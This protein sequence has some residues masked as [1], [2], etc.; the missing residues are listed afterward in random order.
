MLGI[1]LIVLA[2]LAAAGLAIAYLLFPRPPILDASSL[3]PVDGPRSITVVLVDATDDL[4][5]VTKQEVAKRLADVAEDLPAYGLLDLRV[6]DPPT[7]GSRS[8]FARCN[9]GDGAGLS[10]FTGNPALARARW[11]E[12]F[13]KPAID[14]VNNSLSS[15]EASFSP[16]MA[17]IQRI[18]IERFTGKEL[19]KLPR[20]LIVVSDMLEN[21]SAYEQYLGDLT[22]QRYQNSP[23]YRV[24][25][26]DLH[27][28]DV[29]VL[30]VQRATKR[31]I[32][33]ASLAIFWAE[34]FKDNHVGNFRAT[35]LQGLS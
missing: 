27:G 28:A 6:L 16:I 31:P 21:T 35:K 13:Q 24:F 30:Y 19:E 25:R 9:P 4:A 5:A 15:S 32:S 8:I 17:A 12:S 34:W 22:F 11:L 29:S 18:A 3:C 20:S 33:S 1:A 2:L 26:T 14:G 7:Q 10:E 23:A